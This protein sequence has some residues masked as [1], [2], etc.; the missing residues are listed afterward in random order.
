MHVVEPESG[1]LAGGDVG[2]GRLASPES[3]VAAVEAHFARTA[4]GDLTGAKVLISAGGTREPIDAVRVIANRSSGKQGYALAAAA[5]ARGAAVTIVSTVDLPVPEGVDVVH[6]ET[7]AE[8]Q[9]ALE[10]R[11]PTA[12]VVVMAAA[13]ADF[14]PVCAADHK[15]KKRDGI[16]EIVLEP[17]PD[18][19]AGLG[20]RKPDGQVFVGFAAETDDLVA[21]ARRKL[22]AKRLD[23]I[24]AND[25]GAPPHGLPTR[26]QRGDHV[27]PGRTAD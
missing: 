27:R 23:L 1:R 26:H 13:V 20:A 4:T 14:R 18:I 22:A 5:I 3:I 19:L 2:A 6:V 12:D 21:N 17:T 8:M 10:E 25:V 11:A 9:A 7:A 15:L 16:P 24:V